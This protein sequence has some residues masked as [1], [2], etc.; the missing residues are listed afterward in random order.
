V[1]A[2]KKRRERGER[3]RKICCLSSDFTED[4]SLEDMVNSCNG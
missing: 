3:E 1:K 4:L 2:K